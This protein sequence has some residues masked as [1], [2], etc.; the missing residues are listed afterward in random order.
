MCPACLPVFT[1]FQT[2]LS[3]NHLSLPLCCRTIVVVHVTV[4]R[5]QFSYILQPW[6]LTSVEDTVTVLQ[7]KSLSAVRKPPVK[8]EIDSCEIGGAHSGVVKIQFSWDVTSCGAISSRRFVISGDNGIFR[9]VFF[10]RMKRFWA[11][12]AWSEAGWCRG[13][14]LV[15][16]RFLKYFLYSKAE[17]SDFRHTWVTVSTADQRCSVLYS[18][19]TNH[20]RVQP[21]TASIWNMQLVLSDSNFINT[22][23]ACMLSFSFTCTDTNFSIVISN[24]FKTEL[25]KSDR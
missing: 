4:T 19:R 5:T 12:F 23:Q 8:C 6:T 3:L 17:Q 1:T 15:S 22:S 25:G 13:L 20:S 11:T 2:P 9:L 18:S 10:L 24:T 21:G 14:R 7:L 16:Q